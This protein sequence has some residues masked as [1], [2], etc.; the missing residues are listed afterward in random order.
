MMETRMLHFKHN[1]S[2][3]NLHTTRLPETPL[4][5]FEG[6]QILQRPTTLYHL[7]LNRLEYEVIFSEFLDILNYVMIEE[8]VRGW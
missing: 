2:Q 8:S 3:W 6:G 7:P 4:F 5:S 1:D